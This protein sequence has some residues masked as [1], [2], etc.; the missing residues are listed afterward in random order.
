MVNTTRSFWVN[1]I[2]LSAQKPMGIIRAPTSNFNI[3]LP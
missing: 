1:E 3:P 2:M